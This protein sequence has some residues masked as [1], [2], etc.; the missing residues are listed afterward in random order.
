MLFLLLLIGKPY[1][2]AYS[3]PQSLYAEYFLWL[4]KALMSDLIFFYFE[5]T[6]MQNNR[7]LDVSRFYISR[8]LSTRLLG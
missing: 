4:L 3:G 6:V 5:V 8:R 1:E 7:F 2:I